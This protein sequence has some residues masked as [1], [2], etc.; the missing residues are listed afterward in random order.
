MEKGNEQDDDRGVGK[1]KKKSEDG[2]VVRGLDKVRLNEK[3]IIKE[4]KS[5]SPK[6]WHK[7]RINVS[8]IKER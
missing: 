5:V 4:T 7:A 6:Y 3:S 2:N 1:K 8:S